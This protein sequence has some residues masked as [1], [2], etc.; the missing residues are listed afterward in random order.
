M[1]M[2]VFDDQDVPVPSFA[3]CRYSNVSSMSF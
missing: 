2:A 3:V 1:K